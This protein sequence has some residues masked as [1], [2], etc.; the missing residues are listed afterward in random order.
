MLGDAFKCVVSKLNPLNG[1][2][3]ETTSEWIQILDPLT[4]HTHT[5]DSSQSYCE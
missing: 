5:C 4:R 1:F 2:S 3:L